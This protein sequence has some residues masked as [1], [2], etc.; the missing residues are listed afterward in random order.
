MCPEHRRQYEREAKRRDPTRAALTGSR[1]R[2]AAKVYLSRNPFCVLRLPGCEVLAVTVD[3]VIP[4][5][6]RP[7][8][9]YDQSNWRPACRHCNSSRKD[10]LP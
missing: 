1:W 7:D 9:M 6:K 8:L 3:H 5:S 4:R 2:K 10:R